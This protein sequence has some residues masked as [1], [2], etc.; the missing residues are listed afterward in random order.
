MRGIRCGNCRKMGTCTVSPDGTAFKCWKDHGN[1]H[2]CGTS[3]SSNHHNPTANPALSVA[4]SRRFS[5]AEDAI[6]AAGKSIKGWKLTKVWTY[7]GDAERVARFDCPD[8]SKQ[9][10]PVHRVGTHWHI[11]DPKGLWPLYLGDGVEELPES[12]RTVYVVEG[13]K[14]CD[15]A[16]SMQM[17]AVTSSHGASSA[18]KSDWSKLARHDGE[19]ILIPDNDDAGEKYVRDV[20]RLIFSENPQARLKIVRL[21]GLLTGGDI[22]QFKEAG[23]RRKQIKD[24]AAETAPLEPHAVLGGPVL[25]CMADVERTEIDWLWPGRIPLGRITMLVGQPGL[26]KSFLTCDMTARVTTGADW[27]DGKKC[28]TGSVILICGEDDP[29]DTIR[30]RLNAHGASVNRVHLLS[31][32]RRIGEDGKLHEVMFTLADLPSLETALKAHRDCKLVVIDPIGSFIGGKVDTYRENEVR[33]VLAPVAKLAEKYGATVLVVAHRRKAS[34]NSADD[35]TMGSKGFTGIAR[36]VW[37]LSR[38]PQNKERRL[39]LP[40]KN[41]L[42]REGDGLA[43]TIAGELPAIEWEKEPVMMNADEALAIENAGDGPG[44]PATNR[45]EAEKWLKEQLAD[46]QKHP[47]KEL[48]AAAARAGLKHRTVERAATALAVRSEKSG[49][50]AGSCWRLPTPAG[51]GDQSRQLVA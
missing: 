31:M 43:F 40:G 44:R 34:G 8:G 32:V 9:F 5:D 22:E 16:R 15:I 47:V 23:G 14:C 41:N 26:G 17:A 27:P 2:Q 3:T 33:E 20:A 10:R 30:P 7:P 19:I 36:A 24:I 35:L 4:Q 12:G 46:G 49:F 11:G 39:M 45:I 38:D 18:A 42:A 6:A 48:M 28:P 25:I 37:H 1:V 51:A 21:P 50:G 13:E 29:G